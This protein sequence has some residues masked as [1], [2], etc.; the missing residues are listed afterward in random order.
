MPSLSQV[1]FISL[2]QFCC[3]I[4]IFDI[5]LP[6]LLGAVPSPAYKVLDGQSPTFSD[7]LLIEKAVDF[8][9]LV[10]VSVTIHK[11]RGGL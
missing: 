5:V 6:I 9:G 2:D 11:D 7:C 8:E 1:P 10:L 4:E 3:I